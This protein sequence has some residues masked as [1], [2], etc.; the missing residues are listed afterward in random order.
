MPCLYRSDYG[1][2]DP[3]FDPLAGNG[4]LFLGFEAHRD[5]LAGARNFGQ[6]E[7]MK[8]QL[9]RGE[10]IQWC[11]QGYGWAHQ[12]PV[13]GL[14]VFILVA[15]ILPWFVWRAPKLARRLKP[16]RGLPRPLS[17]QAP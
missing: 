2:P 11:E 14:F 3:H 1:P 17:R 5:A 4:V 7:A 10:Q 8:R 9:L 13:D 16:N 15:I 12:K 6:L